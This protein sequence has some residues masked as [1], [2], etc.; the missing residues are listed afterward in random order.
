MDISGRNLQCAICE[1]LIE[2]NQPFR[3]FSGAL[4]S[5]GDKT[6]PRTRV[7]GPVR[8]TQKYASFTVCGNEECG[9]TAIG[10]IWRG[11]L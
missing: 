2:A 5:E 6:N 3:I 11:T 8:S 9:T 7:T 1:S 4:C 10:R